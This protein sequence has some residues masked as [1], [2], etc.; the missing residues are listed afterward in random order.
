MKIIKKDFSNVVN[1]CAAV[2]IARTRGGT[3]F[4]LSFKPHAGMKEGQKVYVTKK[5]V[6]SLITNLKSTMEAYEC[7][8]DPYG[9]Y[10]KK[11]TAAGETA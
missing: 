1:D 6:K 2:N 7:M 4:E 3:V 8:Y 5:E 11:T 10:Y 9:Y